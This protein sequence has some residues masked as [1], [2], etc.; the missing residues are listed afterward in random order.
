VKSQVQE[1]KG[2]GSWNPT[3]DHG[4]GPGGRLYQTC[5]S[6]MTLEV[7]YRYMPMYQRSTGGED[8]L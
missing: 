5:L 2:M 4:A 7:Y 1:E 3:G 8:K 6:V